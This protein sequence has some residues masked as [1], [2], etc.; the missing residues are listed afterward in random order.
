MGPEI[1]ILTMKVNVEVVLVTAT[2]KTFFKITP[3]VL[4]ISYNIYTFDH[5]ASVY[6][7]RTI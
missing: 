4:M 3:Q 1:P 6:M 5:L 2:S 7:R